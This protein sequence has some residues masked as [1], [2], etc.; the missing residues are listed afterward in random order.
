MKTNPRVT[1]SVFL[2][3][4]LFIWFFVLVSSAF[5]TLDDAVIYW[6]MDNIDTSGA[7][8][9][10]LGAYG[11]DATIANVDTGQTG[12]LSEAY[13]YV[14][15]DA[16]N[17]IYGSFSGVD[18]T[19]ATIGAWYSSSTATTTQLIH[20]IRDTSASNN[21]MVLNINNGYPVCGVKANGDGQTTATYSVDIRDG[22]YHRIVCSYVASTR[23]IK[24]YVDG[25]LRASTTLTGTGT[26][27]LMSIDLAQQG[28]SP[29][30]AGEYVD[31]DIDDSVV[32]N[33][34][35]T[36]GGCAV[37]STCGGEIA[38]DWNGGLGINP[39]AVVVSS[40]FTIYATDA[41]T[42][43]SITDMDL[44]FS[45]SGGTV[46]NFTGVSSPYVTP[47][48]TSLLDLTG[49][50]AWYPLNYSTTTN[51][52]GGV[53]DIAHANDGD[54][55]GFNEGLNFTSS[56]LE[57]N[58]VDEYIT[59]PSFTPT[60]SFTIIG[61]FVADDLTNYDRLF[62]YLNG[63]TNRL[64]IGFLNNKIW[65]RVGNL[66]DTT[67][68]TTLVVGNTY[69]YALTYSGGQAQLYLNG[70]ADDDLQTGITFTGT[71]PET[72][73]I[74]SS[75][76]PASFFKGSIDNV[77][78]LDRAL[79]ADEVKYYNEF[80]NLFNLT[81]DAETYFPQEFESQDIQQGNITTGLTQ[82]PYIN[83]TNAFN[84]LPINNNFNI[85][86]FT[87]NI[88]TFGNPANNFLS[89]NNITV[90]SKFYFEYNNTINT[91]IKVQG[92]RE[93][94]QKIYP[95]TT[96]K[97][98]VSVNYPK[99]FIAFSNYTTY[100]GVNYTRTLDV[101]MIINYCA[102]TPAD[103]NLYLNGTSIYSNSIISGCASYSQ[104]NSSYNTT[105]TSSTEGNYSV[106]AILLN[107]NQTPIHYFS[108]DNLPPVITLVTPSVDQGFTPNFNKNVSITCTDSLYP[109]LTYNFSLNYA[110][111]FYGNLA[112]GTTQTNTTEIAD[113]TN[114]FFGVC[115][116][117]FS[118]TE[119]VINLTAYVKT[120]NIINEKLG[121]PLSLT[122]ITQLRAW[123]DDNSTFFDFKAEGTTS[124]NVIGV[125][126]TKIRLEL[127]YPNNDFIVRYIDLLYIEED[128]FSVCGMPNG[129]QYYE[130]LIYSAT[131]KP[132]IAKNQ[133]TNCYIAA[134]TTRFAYQDVQL[135]RAFTI[136]S[137]YYLYTYDNGVQ[138]LLASLDG[139]IESN[140]NLDRLEFASNTYNFGIDSSALTFRKTGDT[141]IQI[142]YN[143]LQGNLQTAELIIT[144]MDNG[145]EVFS[146]DTFADPNE[147]TLYFDYGTLS[148]LNESTIFKAT[149]TTTTSAGEESSTIRYFDTNAS[150][151]VLQNGVAITISI[152]LLLFGFTLTAVRFTFSFFGLFISL[153]SL[154][155]L[156]LAV[157][158]QVT[159]FLS[160]ISIILFVYVII[161]M[162]YQNEATIA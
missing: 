119:E 26:D 103:I 6:S 105:V 83:I 49:L 23:A 34:A 158:S 70:V 114:Y 152:M 13:G 69:E 85:S 126:E 58:G 66:P 62:N 57:F 160:G 134:D 124:V 1:K 144:R 136:D 161:T 91:S 118:S 45:F 102:Q 141:E 8:L 44:S 117:A 156:A 21:F 16:N 35:L 113:G 157:G 109:S 100:Q 43:S 129:T 48:Y 115:S 74:G 55:I 32:Y 60:N 112:S 3:F 121:I 140:V 93:I 30:Y 98:N 27:N 125:N 162:V 123:F 87:G 68:D 10:D 29:F 148:N 138:V 64:Y 86:L 131:S 12:I 47:F 36:D 53:I 2:F 51:T 151:G 153:A 77:L 46:F 61:S 94:Q 154:G 40:N 159:L 106:Q 139:S 9:T 107:V 97:I 72:A 90:G 133:Y 37:S 18:Y 15:S 80:G 143:N 22:D 104:V 137:S 56:G 81:I 111:I 59:I 63:A 120:L 38:E 19:E 145:A 65:Y 132:A 150:I 75:Q 25:V 71:N 11:A 79:T 24:L 96:P 88:A 39:Y 92:A 50:Q 54:A 127:Q 7:T 41:D 42:S 82:M 116:D 147:W 142:Y 73:Y 84:N 76:V 5:A 78:I 20:S 4:F 149:L 52:T 146:L 130:Q 135:L 128:N 89:V 95:Q 31:G 14:S 99:V 101:S 155:V 33:R 17:R 108:F 122:N 28:F 110:N 67:G